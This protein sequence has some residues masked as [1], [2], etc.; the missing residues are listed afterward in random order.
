[1]PAPFSFRP[2]I[3]L[4][5]STLFAVAA[6][7]QSSGFVNHLQRARSLHKSGELP[8]ARKHAVSAQ[9]SATSS[10]QREQANSLL[11]DID[12]TIARH[13]A[14][15]RLAKRLAEEAEPAEATASHEGD[16]AL[17]RERLSHTLQ[18]FTRDHGGKVLE[19][20]LSEFRCHGGN[21]RLVVMTQGKP[22]AVEIDDPGNILITQAG[23]HSDHFDFRC[24][25]Q[26]AQAVKVGY[27]PANKDGRVGFLRILEF[28]PVQPEP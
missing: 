4:L 7:G 14:A 20:T 12:N 2:G 28:Q 15:A 9:K 21:P 27:R 16:V 10:K 8:E 6:M 22:V 13:Q 11:H 25:K 24:G 5:L 23:E 19:G 17:D 1:M 3:V 26:K 18:V